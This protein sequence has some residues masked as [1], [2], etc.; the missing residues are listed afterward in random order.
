[1]K[2]IKNIILF[3]LIIFIFTGAT[4]K[5]YCKTSKI[6]I[7]VETKDAHIMKATLSYIKIK[8]KKKYPTI[9][10]L[11]SLG[12]SSEDW[13]NLI[14]DLNNAGYAVLA[15]DLR[16]HGKSIYNAKFQIKSW[17]YFTAKTYQKFPTDVVAVLKQA[18]KQSKK[19]DFTNWA[20][21]GADIG[22][23]TAILATKAFYPKPK[24]MVL[25]SPSMDFKGLYV[26][27]V[28]TE[29]GTMPIL[30]MV[31]L[32]DDYSVQEQ[33]KLSKFAQGA[34]YAKN[35]TTGGMGMMMLT[36]N[37]GM[38]KDITGWLKTVVK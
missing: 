25:I 1:M 9:V 23:N 11:H 28:M 14:P 24:A 2:L 26:P 18:Q 3:T 20:I 6:D 32:Q 10:L 22:A 4:Q 7:E 27:I 30:S 37:P 34:F 38:S 31:S 5:A 12:Y 8:D 17:T 16:G 33:K 15:I 21:V 36:T 29:I 13:G 19:I 35:Y